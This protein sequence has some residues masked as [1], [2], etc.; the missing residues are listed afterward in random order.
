MCQHSAC[1]FSGLIFISGMS[2]LAI[3][4]S[5]AVAT[6]VKKLHQTKNS[7]SIVHLETTMDLQGTALAGQPTK[8]PVL[9]IHTAV[10][11]LE[12]NAYICT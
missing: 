2:L 10:L 1:D 8:C 6:V 5:L 11:V 3:P 12:G 9:V 4:A 7:V